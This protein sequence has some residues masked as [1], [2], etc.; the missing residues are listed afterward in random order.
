MP[1]RVRWVPKRVKQRIRSVGGV[2]EPGG[3]PILVHKG[4][5]GGPEGHDP[6]FPALTR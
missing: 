3:P 5:H 1:I 2:P 6:R 4:G